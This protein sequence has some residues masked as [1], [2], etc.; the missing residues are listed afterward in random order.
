MTTGR[1]LFRAWPFIY[2]LGPNQD[3]RLASVAGNAVIT[4]IPLKI[5]QDS[6]FVLRAR[7]FRVQYDPTVAST[8]RQQTGL[9]QVQMR[10]SGPDRNYFSQVPVPQNVEM[11]AGGQAGRPKPVYPNVIYPASS[12]LFMDVTNNGMTTL[13]NLTFYWFGVKMFPWGLREEF[14]YPDVFGTVPFSYDGT[15]ASVPVTTASQGVRNV[16]TV[17]NDTDFVLRS[18]SSG[19]T[20]GSNLTWEIFIRLWDSYVYPYSSDFVHLDMIAG[21]PFSL[22][23]F[24]V[25]PTP[26]F[27]SPA[28]GNPG[29]FFVPEIYIP[30][31]HFK[32]YD[33]LRTDGPFVGQ[34]AVTQN[35]PILF[36][37]A[38]VF[39][40]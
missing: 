25:D 39:P 22:I 10:Y 1:P 5:D 37:G 4:N 2:V 7:G 36:R 33:I 26:T 14:T 11:Y 6:P 16:F 40:K 18:I 12:T 29:W 38:K 9:N 27:I 28:W 30:F 13:I 3:S 8:S 15:V 24:P 35:F 34:G 21:N 31:K 19:I 23:T 32:Y 20:T 17:D